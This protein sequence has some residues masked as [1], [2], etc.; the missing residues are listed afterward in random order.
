MTDTGCPHPESDLVTIEADQTVVW[1]CPLC[2]S[3]RDNNG[4][5]GAQ[6]GTWRAPSG[7][8]LPG[9]TCSVC[10]VMNGSLKELLTECR[11]CG[12]PRR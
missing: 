1:W 3:I 9:W 8:V 7:L 12:A 4:D 5:H 11:S 10:Q 2:G 6:T